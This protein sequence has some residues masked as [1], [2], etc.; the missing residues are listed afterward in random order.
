[1][2][3]PALRQQGGPQIHR[4]RPAGSQLQSLLSE[5]ATFTRNTMALAN[6]QHDTFLLYPQPTELQA[7]AFDLLG[8]SPRM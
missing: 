7:A 3:D 4:G 5:L 8:I 2:H 6:G 1:M